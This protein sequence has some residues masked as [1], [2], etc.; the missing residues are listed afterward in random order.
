MNAIRVRDL[1]KSYGGRPAVDGVALDVREGEV[2]ALLGPNG[3][4][5][6]TTVEI[7]E[8][9]RRRDGGEV[10]VLGA[11]PATA[12]RSWRADIGIVQQSATDLAET[13]VREAVRHFARYYPKPRDPEEVVDLVGLTSQAGVRAGRLSGGQRRRLDVA[14][15][16]VGRPRLLFLDEPTTGFDPEARRQFWRLVRQ[17]SGD[18]T[19]ILLTTHY[20][21]EVEALADRLAVVA[22]GRVVAEGTPATLGGRDRAEALVSWTDAEGPRSRRTARPGE[23]IRSLGEPADLTVTRPTLEDVYLELIA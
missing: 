7:L 1:R 15:G 21:D 10:T 18:G 8:G 4:G 5:K 19:T 2:F 6:S 23:L 9:L 12:P 17:L 20:L 16:I 14:L 11:D 13:T 3:A 22:A